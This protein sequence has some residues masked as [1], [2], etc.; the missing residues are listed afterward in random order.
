MSNPYILHMTDCTQEDHIMPDP[1]PDP[2]PQ[3]PLGTFITI[4]ILSPNTDPLSSTEF[5]TTWEYIR[6]RQS[7]SNIMAGG[8]GY[9]WEEKQ[10]WLHPKESPDEVSGEVLRGRGERMLIGGSRLD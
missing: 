8:Q 5:D 9:W 10:I 4:R 2:F 7:F 3:H 1:P 6:T